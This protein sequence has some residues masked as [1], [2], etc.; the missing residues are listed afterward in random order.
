MG[1]LAED[2]ETPYSAASSSRCPETGIRLD[3]SPNRSPGRRTKNA[4]CPRHCRCYLCDV[5]KQ[6]IKRD[7][8]GSPVAKKALENNGQRP[9]RTCIARVH[10]YLHSIPHIGASRFVFGLQHTGE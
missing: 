9:N 8:G 6:G 1:A 3:K 5:H 10:L 4:S 7:Q 2:W